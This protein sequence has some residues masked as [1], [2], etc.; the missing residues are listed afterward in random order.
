MRREPAP[1]STD[2]WGGGSWIWGL[3]RVRGPGFSINT[4]VLLAA[5]NSHSRLN[6]QSFLSVSVSHDYK[7]VWSHKLNMRHLRSNTWGAEPFYKDSD[8]FIGC[9]ALP[10]SHGYLTDCVIP[11]KNHTFGSGS[12]SSTVRLK[13]WGHTHIQFAC[14]ALAAYR[15]SSV[16]NLYLPGSESTG[17]TSAQTSLAEIHVFSHMC[18]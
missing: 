18:R 14:A 6:S 7:R 3:D 10:H 13:K 8:W 1:F 15:S 5:K 16:S 17:L 2:G 4:V 11:F 12:L 9:Y